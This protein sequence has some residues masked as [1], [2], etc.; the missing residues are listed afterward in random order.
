MRV[1][2]NN[3]RSPVEAIALGRPAVRTRDDD[4]LAESLSIWIEKANLP[5][6]TLTGRALAHLP[7][8]EIL[9]IV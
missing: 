8:L 7:W 9:Q 5:P 6:V 2:V 3:V 1:A 4:R